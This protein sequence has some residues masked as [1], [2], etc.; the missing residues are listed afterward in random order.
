LLEVWE[1]AQ[2]LRLRSS[3]LVVVSLVLKRFL[4]TSDSPFSIQEKE[5]NKR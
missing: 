3:H 5:E 4:F 1:K 2:A